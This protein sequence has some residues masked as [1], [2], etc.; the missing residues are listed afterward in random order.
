MVSMSS[1]SRFNCESHRLLVIIQLFIRRDSLRLSSSLMMMHNHYISVNLFLVQ[2]LD[3]A[4]QLLF[5]CYNWNVTMTPWPRLSHQS[6][7]TSHSFKPRQGDGVIFGASCRCCMK[8]RWSLVEECITFS[9]DSGLNS[10][11]VYENNAYIH[12]YNIQL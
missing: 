10:W 7:I 12:I 8:T 4:Q 6:F 1:S 5:Y 11:S 3:N 2:P 9:S